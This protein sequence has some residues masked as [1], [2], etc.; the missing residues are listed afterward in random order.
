MKLYGLQPVDWKDAALS[1]VVVGASGT[2]V[3]FVCV[4]GVSVGGG[5]VCMCACVRACVCVCVCVC[6]C[7][8]VHVC[9]C[10]CVRACSLCACSSVS[11][12]WCFVTEL[13]TLTLPWTLPAGDLAR[14][15]I[16]PALFALYVEGVL[17]P[18]FSIVGYSRSKMTDTEFR[19][20]IMTNLTCRV[21][22]SSSCGDKMDA[23][24]DRL[25]YHPGQY[26]SDSDFAALS[27]RM[28][29]LEQV[30]T[31]LPMVMIVMMMLMM[32]M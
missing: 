30:I 13:G 14:K 12:P 1:I 20:Y 28:D 8:C 32:T 18:N 29:E 16:Y 7:T 4:W 23:F 27:G 31:M 17:P 2:H 9:V 15:K 21:S 24:L 19:D 6:V 11:L 3:C 26:D 10:A 25:Y 5:C 22:D